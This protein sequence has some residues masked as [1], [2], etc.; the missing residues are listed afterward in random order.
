MILLMIHTENSQNI[1]YA[2]DEHDS[3]GTTSNT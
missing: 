1:L 3:C 2:K